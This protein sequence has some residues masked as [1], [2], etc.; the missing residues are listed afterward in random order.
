M[1][2]AALVRCG[3]ERGCW[4][5][6]WRQTRTPHGERNGRW[7]G[8]MPGERGGE[9]RAE[10]EVRAAA[11]PPLRLA[12]RATI[13]AR[14][15]VS[16]PLYA[17]GSSSAGASAFF[18]NASSCTMIPHSNSTMRSASAGLATSIPSLS[19]SPLT[20]QH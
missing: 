7:E 4:W 17:K 2:R 5:S 12:P 20:D 15:R 16:A 6:A 9:V 3:S 11:R 8:M 14:A 10:G 1:R 18:L 13:C 19:S